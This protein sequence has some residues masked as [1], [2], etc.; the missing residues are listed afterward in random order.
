MGS[1]FFYTYTL[2]PVATERSALA[3]RS[4][5]QRLQIILPQDAKPFSRRQSNRA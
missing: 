3:K 4:N 5:F 2:D 1:I